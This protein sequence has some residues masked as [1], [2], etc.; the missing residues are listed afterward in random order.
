M[1]SWR[2]A[3]VCLIG[4]SSSPP[5]RAEYVCV[6]GATGGWACGDQQNPPTAAPLADSGSSRP[7]APPPLLL[8]D[9]KRF[10][11]DQPTA[12]MAPAAASTPP[13]APVPVPSPAVAEPVPAPPT[14]EP[15][16]AAVTARPAPPAPTPA[17]LAG[18]A[19]FAAL[20]P[21]LYTL[22]LAATAT[23]DGFPA[24]LRQLDAASAALPAWQIRVQRGER[25]LWLLCLG[26]FVDPASARAA[27]PAAAKGAFSKS[28]GELQSQLARQ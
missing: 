13:A 4:A 17:G 20:T 25:S 2:L 21:E 8:I 18:N 23:P 24:L 10:Q 11:V 26:S 28:I 7:T 6:P 9:P 22:Q 1:T 12:A 15:T 3:L 5:A 14:P 16:P 19:E 27:T